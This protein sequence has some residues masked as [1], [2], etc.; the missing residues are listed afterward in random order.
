[1]P[2]KIEKNLSK[3][4]VIASE[5]VALISCFEEEITCHRQ[6]MC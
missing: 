4:E 1:M 3:S 2:K 5:F 6:S